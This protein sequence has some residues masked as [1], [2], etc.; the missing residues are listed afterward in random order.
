M[1]KWWLMRILTVTTH[2]SSKWPQLWSEWSDRKSIWSVPDIIF[3]N[4]LHKLSENGLDALKDKIGPY[5]ESLFL[6]KIFDRRNL[7]RN[8]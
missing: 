1:Q 3:A 8:C 6:K 2:R 7:S 4:F 5:G